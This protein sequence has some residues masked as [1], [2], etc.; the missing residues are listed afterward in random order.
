MFDLLTRGIA[1]AIVKCSV[2]SS[3][4]TSSLNVSCSTFIFPAAAPFFWCDLRYEKAS[5]FPLHGERAR[6]AIQRLLSPSS[7]IVIIAATAS[8]N[9]EGGFGRLERPARTLGKRFTFRPSARPA[10]HRGLVSRMT[11]LHKGFSCY[12]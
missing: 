2:Q 12:T 4:A 3:T 11:L 1:G 8:R 6:K 5:A 10:F 7:V 9:S